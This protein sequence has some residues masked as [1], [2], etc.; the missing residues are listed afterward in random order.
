MALL[1]IEAERLDTSE[2]LER[3]RQADRRIL[4][5]RKQDKRGVGIR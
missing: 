1:I 5:A 4:P 3:P 2:T